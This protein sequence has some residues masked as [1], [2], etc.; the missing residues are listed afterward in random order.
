MLYRSSIGD[1]GDLVSTC[2][3]RLVTDPDKHFSKT[4]AP[5]RHDRKEDRRTGEQTGARQ[6][7]LKRTVSVSKCDNTLC[8]IR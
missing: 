8:C 7:A 6:N 2:F 5:R 3:L 4:L 1:L